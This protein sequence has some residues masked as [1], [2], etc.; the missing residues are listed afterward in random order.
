MLITDKIATISRRL[1]AVGE[2]K[3]KSGRHRLELSMTSHRGLADL[4]FARGDIDEVVA[5]RFGRP[6]RL[7][8]DRSEVG[9]CRLSPTRPP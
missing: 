8:I 5:G 1:R 6:Y 3:A 7:S 2:D 4:G 9:R